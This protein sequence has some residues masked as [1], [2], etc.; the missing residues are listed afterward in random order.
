MLIDHYNSPYP[1]GLVPTTLSTSQQLNWCRLCYPGPYSQSDVSRWIQR[2]LINTIKI[3]QT[4]WEKKSFFCIE[5]S[6]SCL[7]P[8]HSSRSFS[9]CLEYRGWRKGLDTLHCLHSLTR[10]M[11]PEDGCFRSI[12]TYTSQLSHLNY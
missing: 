8:D 3:G 7:S 10:E 6:K 1:V 11:R 5:Q 4:H 2:I 12:N 9:Q